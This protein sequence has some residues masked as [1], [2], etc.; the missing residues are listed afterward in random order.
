MSTTITSQRMTVRNQD[1]QA[2]F[3]GSVVLTKGTLVVHSDKLVVSFRASD[4]TAMESKNGEKGIMPE[5]IERNRGKEKDKKE[6]ARR[7]AVPVMSNRSVSTI[8]AT[9]RVKIDKEGGSATCQKALYYQD[10]EKIVLT[11]EPIAWEKG[12]R[13]TG[14]QI[15]MFLAEDRSVVEGGSHVRIEGEGGPRR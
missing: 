12:T 5:R 15:T 8:E 1:G 14:K 2:I 9:G 4:Q 10:E 6:R 13:V 3:E 11:G 7:E